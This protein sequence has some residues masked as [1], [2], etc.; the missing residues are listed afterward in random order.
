MRVVA[1][2]PGDV[3]NQILFFP[4]I[5]DIKRNY[6][7]AEIDVVV[8]PTAKEAYRVSKSVNDTIPFDFPAN[9]SP[10]DWANLLGVIR[11]RT[12]DVAIAAGGGWGVGLLLWLTGTPARIGYDNSGAKPFLTQIV[13]FRSDR[14]KADSYHDLLQAI[15]INSNSPE[16]GINLPK[17]AIDWAE[18]EQKRLGVK[19]YVLLYPD[20]NYPLTSWQAIAQDFQTRQPDM[21]LLVIQTEENQAIATELSRLCPNVKAT[22]PEELG[23]TAALIAGANLLLCT[24][25]APLELAIALK[26]YT[27]A[28]LSAGGTASIQGGDRFISVA[29]NTANLADIAPSDVLQKVWGG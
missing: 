27:L 29:S 15:N 2:V 14:S 1:L 24:E 25:Q 12:Y 4:T 7:D 8:E 26:V 3:R 20:A 19:G 13:P 23:Q 22:Q 10:A 17:S 6:P 11:D 18:V 5:D 28:L 21:P 16:L 9:N